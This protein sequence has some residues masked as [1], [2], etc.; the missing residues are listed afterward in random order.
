M[1]RMLV[2]LLASIVLVPVAVGAQAPTDEA[3]SA[4]ESSVE[5]PVSAQTQVQ[6]DLAGE[7]TELAAGEQTGISLTEGLPA[8][9]QS[10]HDPDPGLED[11]E[12]DKDGG[13]EQ[14]EAEPATMPSPEETATPAG[15]AVLGATA[16]A[17]FRWRYL[18]TGVFA[19]LYSRLSRDELLENETRRAL[20]DLIEDEPGLSTQELCDRV[21]AGW[22]NTVYHLQRLE[23]AGF[24][25]SEKQGHHR[26][27]YKNGEVGSDDSEAL[28]VL[29]NDNA[30]KI[31]RYLVA[32]PGANQTDVCEALD[33]SPS[34]AHKWISRLE[35]Q[36]LVDSEREWRSKHYEPDDRLEQLVERAA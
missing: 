29:K 17:A 10:G 36:D 14:A 21:D 15:L 3:R 31:A 26:R 1:Q 8:A 11:E 28:G 4:T 27:F 25:T 16:Y 33:I 7:Q 34:L 30:N 24:V 20:H 13:E 9:D 32:E 5:E 2:V 6:A 35:E 22:G 23:Q 19:P 12:E 18:L